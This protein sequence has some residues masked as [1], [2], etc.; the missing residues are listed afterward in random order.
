VLRG[1]GLA[2]VAHFHAR[3]EAAAGR[4]AAL[5]SAVGAFQ[6]VERSAVEEE[7]GRGFSRDLAGDGDVAR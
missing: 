4:I 6:G 1:H 2:V 7:Q 5:R 3:I